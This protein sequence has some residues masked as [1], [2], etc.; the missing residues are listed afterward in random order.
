L[1]FGLKLNIIP[2]K[3]RKLVAANASAINIVGDVVITIKTT[4]GTKPIL[5]KKYQIFRV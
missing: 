5:I 4:N 3:R 1:D 2:T